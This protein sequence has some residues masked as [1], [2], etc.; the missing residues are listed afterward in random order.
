MKLLTLNCHSWQEKDQINKM[1]Y[2]AKVIAEEGYEVIALQEVNQLI[3]EKVLYGD[4]REGNFIDLLCK[5]LKTLGA[6]YNYRWDYHHVGYDIFHEGT[7]ILFKGEAEEDLGEFIGKTKDTSFWKTRKFTLVSKIV[8]GERIDFY[9][10]HMGWWKD[11]DNP[12]EN[13]LDELIEF[14]TKRGNRYFLMG[15]FNNDANV[16]GEGYDYL[17]G[18]N[19]RDTYLDA[20]EKDSGVTVPGVIAGWEGKCTNPKR[21]D[22]IF[23]NEKCEIKRSEVIFN[24]ENKKIISDHFGVAI[25]I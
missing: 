19:L 18:K 4:I 16:K 6:Q 5:E 12:F 2:L 10:C 25:E 24:G 3:E 7:G 20:L 17:M 22:F 21:I 9:C 8:S 15:D 13:Q 11:L 14:A 1:K 23:T